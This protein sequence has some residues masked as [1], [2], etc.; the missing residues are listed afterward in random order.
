MADTNDILQM[1]LKERFSGSVPMEI[2]LLSLLLP[3][4]T[5]EG[6][7][8]ALLVTL[9]N[10]NIA[11]ANFN[12]TV[13][14]AWIRSAISEKLLAAGGVR[15]ESPLQILTDSKG[16]QYVR[17]AK[18]PVTKSPALTAVPVTVIDAPPSNPTS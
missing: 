12:T 4:E 8:V 17:P 3:Y 7:Y 9:T 1:Y 11:I 10:G 13:W 5:L 16:N 15:L 2:R 14:P 6:E 18:K